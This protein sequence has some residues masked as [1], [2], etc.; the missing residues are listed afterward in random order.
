MGL[1][2]IAL[3]AFA[4]C[5]GGLLLF[6]ESGVATGLGIMLIALACAALVSSLRVGRTSQPKG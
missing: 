5:F 6:S 2:G 1:K 4:V 3:G